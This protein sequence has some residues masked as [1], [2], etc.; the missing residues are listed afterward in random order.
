VALSR[1]RQVVELRQNS[2]HLIDNAVA[3]L[4]ITKIMEQ[5][6]AGATEELDR[7]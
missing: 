7:E 1:A 4:V 5:L 3:D 6:N 2:S